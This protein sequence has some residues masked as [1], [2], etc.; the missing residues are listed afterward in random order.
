MMTVKEKSTTKHLVTLLPSERELVSKLYYTALKTSIRNVLNQI[1]PHSG[2]LSPSHSPSLLYPLR[3]RGMR[4]LP[5]SDPLLGVFGL[6]VTP[7]KRKKLNAFFGHS[8]SFAHPKLYIIIDRRD[9]I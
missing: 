3:A 1:L 4:S 5:P 6:R 2:L 7:V 8:R 9:E